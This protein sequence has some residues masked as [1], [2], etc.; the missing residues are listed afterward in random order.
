MSR[1]FLL[2][3]LNGDWLVHI[4]GE[5]KWWTKGNYSI[6]SSKNIFG[7]DKSGWVVKDYDGLQIFGLVTQGDPWQ[8]DVEIVWNPHII[9]DTENI[10]DSVKIIAITDYQPIDLTCYYICTGKNQE[11]NTWSGKKIKLQKNN[12]TYEWVVEEQEVQDL[13]SQGYDVII[14]DIYNINATVRILLFSEFTYIINTYTQNPADSKMILKDKQAFVNGEKIIGEIQTIDTS[15][16][17]PTISSENYSISIPSGYLQEGYIH[18]IDVVTPTT[19]ING[20]EFTFSVTQ[21]YV[22]NYTYSIDVVAS[23]LKLI[24]NSLLFSIASGYVKAHDEKEI[25]LDINVPIYQMVL[26]Q[27]NL[28]QYILNITIDEAIST[29]GINK[30]ENKFV[31]IVTQGYLKES[32][33]YS[34]DVVTPAIGINGDKFT[35]SVIQGYVKGYTYSINIVIPIIGINEDTSQYSINIPQGYLQKDYIHNIDVVKP[36]AGINEEENKFIFSVAQGYVKEYEKNITLDIN[37]PNYQMVLNNDIL[38]I[39][40]ATIDTSNI[41]PIIQNS[42]YSINIPQ[43]YLQEG[44]IHNIDIVTP[45][46]NINNE[47]KQLVF[48][49]VSGYINEYTHNIKI[50]TPQIIETETGVAFNVASGY[51]QEDYVYNINKNIV[52]PNLTLVNNSLLFSVNS[53]YING[54]E[55]NIALDI[56]VPVQ[57]VILNQNQDVLNI[58]IDEVTPTVG[59]NEEEN[60]FTF[61]VAQGYLQE[62]Y[63]YSID[64][65]TPQININNEENKLTF[66][67]ASGYI[68]E[69][70]HNIDIVTPN[71]TLVNNNLLFSVNSGYINKYEKNITLD[72]NVPVQSVILNQNQNVL[73]ITVKIYDGQVY[74]KPQKDA[75]I[76]HTENKFIKNNI[77]IEGDVNLISQNI[78]KGIV[79]FGVQGTLQGEIIEAENVAYGYV[80]ENGLFQKIDLSGDTVEK[81]GEAVEMDKIVLFNLPQGVIGE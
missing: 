72:I 67:V 43:G 15:H 76:I 3:N 54:Y 68:N 78:K 42:Q 57:S 16:I 56:N 12:D 44:Y 50:V 14:N 45:Q 75:T 32:Y 5:N 79:I 23:N 35:F 37:V 58:T 26:N 47:E 71:L 13:K 48:S 80:D 17:G 34:I 33:T 69:Y 11:K 51:L 70:A 29:A 49:V 74:F 39:T 7:I 10:G 81:V 64:V 22:E 28:N 19:G 53:G 40:I 30:D 65:V 61:S 20:D 31:F 63:T 55:K 25:K 46:I 60:K 62:N 21:G 59:I 38:N 9:S 2:D 18:S 8:T 27:D 6:V 73:D 66:S 1:N 77:T 52:T 41:K 36:I 4:Q 24:G